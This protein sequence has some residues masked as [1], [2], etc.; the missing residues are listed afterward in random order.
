MTLLL[1]IYL[2]VS[3]FAIVSIKI[4][5]EFSMLKCVGMGVFL[6]IPIVLHIVSDV[7]M[8]LGNLAFDMAFLAGGEDRASFLLSAIKKKMK[9]EAKNIMGDR[10]DEDEDLH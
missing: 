9:G 7:I 1:S 10:S 5:T 6:P 4:G 3:L 2:L 8:L